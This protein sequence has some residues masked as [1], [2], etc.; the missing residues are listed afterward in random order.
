MHV[1]CSNCGARYAVDPAALGQGGRT[2]QCAR[3]SHRWFEKAQATAV[4]RTDAS[5][6]RERPVP[7]FVIRP[8]VQGAGLPA[9]TRPRPRARWGQWLS[10]TV[11]LL[12]LLGV[13]AYAWRGEIREQLP[14]QWRPILNLDTFRA[15]FGPPSTAVRAS[16]PD[17][18]RLEIDLDAS[19]IELVDGRYVVEGEV[20]NAGRIPGSTSQLKLIFRKNDDVIGE[21]IYPLV[22]GP[23]RPG[24]RLSFRQVLDDPPPGTTD[25]VPAVE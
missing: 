2:V 9:L 24:A 7:D 20:F 19:K 8:Q 17:R 23:I 15:L 4:P 25:I 5:A 12:L 22:E 1:T 11:V 14:P 18:A 3:C 6:P 10:G 13:A 16:P 21:R